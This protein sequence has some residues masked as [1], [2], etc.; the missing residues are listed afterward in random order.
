MALQQLGIGADIVKLAFSIFFG[1]CALAFALAVGLGAKE[2]AGEYI[3]EL[4]E[5]MKKGGK[6]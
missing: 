5:G 6:K 3:R 1:A 2:L 4:S